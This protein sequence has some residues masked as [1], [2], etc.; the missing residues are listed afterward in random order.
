M[1]AETEQGVLKMLNEQVTLDRQV[2]SAKGAVVMQPDFNT[3]D[4][5]RIFDIDQKGTLSAADI[6][7]G[8]ADMGVHVTAEDVDLFV[9]RHDKNRD[10]RLDY[11]EFAEAF[12]P[13]DPYY[14]SI[15]ARRPG[16]QRRVNPYRKDDLFSHS[17]ACTFKELFRTML[18]TEGSAEATR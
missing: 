8:L 12:T 7:Y 10:G 5:F 16:S 11:R 13:Q 15:L 6:K 18:S 9:Q 14:A 3:R 17:T 2:E 1:Q 4:A